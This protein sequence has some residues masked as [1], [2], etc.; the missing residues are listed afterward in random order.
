MCRP[1][2]SHASEDIKYISTFVDQTHPM[3]ART[4]NASQHVLTKPLPWERGHKMY[5]NLSWPNPSYASEDTKCISTCV[6]QTLPMSARTQNVSQLVLTK[7][8]SCQQR[9]KMYLN[10]W[11]PN[12][13]LAARTQNSTQHVLTKPLPCERG[14]KMYLNLSWPNPSYAREDTKC[15]STCVD[16]TLPMSAR[17]QNVSQLVLTKHFSCQQRNKTYLNFCWPNSSLAARTQNATQYVFTKPLPFQRGHK[18]HLNL[19]RPNPSHACNKSKCI[20]TLESVKSTYIKRAIGVAKN[21]VL[22]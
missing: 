3:P 9:N 10:F 4:Q 8:F 5:L 2:P 7:H 13:S 19:C 17:T 16:Q 15:I 18:M 14:H 11:W 22:D 20:S 1:N 6:D 12:P 21:Q